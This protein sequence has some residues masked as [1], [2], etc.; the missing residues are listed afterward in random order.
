MSSARDREWVS[1]GTADHEF[2][3]PR[4][5]PV[6]AEYSLGIGRGNTPSRLDGPIS[7]LGQV[8][9]RVAYWPAIRLRHC[10]RHC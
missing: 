7:Q 6:D 9:E 8:D 3:A 5:N 2:V 4:R 1:E 10:P